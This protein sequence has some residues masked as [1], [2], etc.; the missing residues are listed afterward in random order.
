MFEWALLLYLILCGMIIGIRH[1]RDKREWWIR[2]VLVASLPI[3]GF[4]MPAFW[5]KRWHDTNASK[6]RLTE[7]DMLSQTNIMAKNQFSVFTK[8]EAEKEM[9]VVPLEEAL[10]VNDLS[11]RRRVI[12]DLLKQ[13]SIGHL[14]VL[15]MAVSNEDSETSHYAVSAIMEVKRKLM[16]MLQEFA[17]QYEENKDDPH[18]LRSYADVLK[19]YMR[20][21]FLDERT[22]LKHNHLYSMLLDRLLE[23]MPESPDAYVEKINTDLDLSNYMEAERAA[24]IYREKYPR[25]EDAYLCLIKVYFTLRAVDKL[26]GTIEELKT[27]PIRLSSRALIVIRFWSKGGPNEYESQTKT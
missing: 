13:D 15:R 19:S 11:T 23:I 21:G 12:I 17:V 5:S 8:P 27:S 26:N 25:S 6:N 9:N 24:L 18:L 1:H 3:I 14:E 16:L 4:L 20:S 10:L 7:L 22:M 2:F